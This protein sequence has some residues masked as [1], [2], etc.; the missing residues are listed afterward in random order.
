MKLCVLESSVFAGMS[1]VVDVFMGSALLEMALDSLSSGW[2][3]SRLLNLWLGW[4]DLVAVF[5]RVCG[6]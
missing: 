3:E 4:F 1:V 6:F 5:A 2:L